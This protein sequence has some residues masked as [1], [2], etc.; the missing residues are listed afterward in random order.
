MSTDQAQQPISLPE[1]LHRI[2]LA[3]SALTDA[4]KLA[5]QRLNAVI[6]AGSALLVMKSTL[7]HGEWQGWVDGNLEGMTIR[8]A[9]NWMKLAKAFREGKVD[10]SN[11]K[12]VRQ[13]YILA[14]IVPE[15]SSEGARRVTETVDWRLHTN[16]AD[17]ALRKIPVSGLSNEEAT[18]MLTGLKPIEQYCMDL[19]GHLA[20]LPP[21]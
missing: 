10:L 20:K 15:V 19:R 17:Y 16:R 6:N 1:L 3:E 8:T 4:T 13:A 5:G 9:Q 7:K 12:G 14:G 11:S 2:A 18:S 21:S